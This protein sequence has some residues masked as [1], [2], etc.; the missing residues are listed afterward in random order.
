MA[1][2][3][4]ECTVTKVDQP[5]HPPSKIEARQQRLERMKVVRRGSYRVPSLEEIRS[6]EWLND[7]HIEAVSI[8]LKAH[9]P[10]KSGLY[11][12]KLGQDL[13]FPVTKPPLVQIVHVADHW[14]TVEGVS[15]SVARVYD[16]MN[17]TTSMDTQSQI[18]AVMQCMAASITLEV[19]NV[20]LQIGSSDCGLYAIA[21]AT[22]LCYGN[23][24]SN[25]R[26]NQSKM[27]SHLI[28]CLEGQKMTP[29]PSRFRRPSHPK[30]EEVRVYCKC[31][32]PDNGEED[33]AACDNCNEWYHLTCGN[34]PAEVFSSETLWLCHMCGES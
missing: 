14:L 5:E 30:I 1:S 15:P 32:L 21:Y 3:R 31:R 20:Q 16:S 22:D 33:M 27:R 7:S 11:D 13:A 24:P 12:P 4:E 6:G 26:Y 2:K 10:D 29:F 34:I 17:Y 25:L 18:A 28:K 9:F 19:Q 23:N 8:L